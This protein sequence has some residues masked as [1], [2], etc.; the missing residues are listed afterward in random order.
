MTGLSGLRILVTRPRG[1]C[2]GLMDRLAALGAQPIHFAAVEIVGPQ[3]IAGLKTVV[4]GL[5]DCDWAIFISPNA[6]T[7]ALNLMQG[8]GQ[9]WPPGVRVAAIGRGSA[10]ELKRLGFG[11][12]LVPEGRFDSESLLAMEPFQN[13]EGQSVLIFR[14]EG[15]RGLLGD[16]LKARGAQVRYAE[17]YRRAPPS[18]DVSGLLRAWARNGLD[19]VVVTSVE[20]L[21]HLYDALGPVGRQWLVRTPLVVV[22]TRQ[23]DACRAL[24]LQG[25]VIVAEG[26]DDNA[27]TAALLAW[28]AGQ[29]PL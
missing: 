9:E 20:G 13:L 5:A 4:A 23:R 21:H 19:A 18:A 10:R 14:G 8:W 6:V 22:G 24:G 16:T 3:D 27:L 17:C 7:H 1:Q 15:G 26:A 28:H 12:V 11:D 29:N 2:Q 25:P